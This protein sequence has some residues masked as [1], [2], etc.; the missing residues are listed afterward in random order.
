MKPVSILCLTSVCVIAF[1]QGCSSLG[2]DCANS[3]TC[4]AAGGASGQGGEAGNGG[5]GNGGQGGQGGGPP[6]ECIPSEAMGVVADSCGV[7]VSSSKGTAGAAGTK[8]E[9]VNTIAEAL[10]IA[11]GKPIY[12]CGEAFDEE[13]VMEA[14]TDVYGALDCENDWSYKPETKA[15]VN[16]PANAIAWKVSGSG[17][18][19]IADVAITAATATD[20][21]MSSI[22]MLVDESTVDL[23][24]CDI[25]AGDGADGAPGTSTGGTAQGGIMGNP[26]LMG[27][28]DGDTVNGGPGPTRTCA[29]GDT[30]TGGTGGLSMANQNGSTGN[31]GTSSPSVTTPLDNG[32][33]G[34]TGPAVGQECDNG[35]VGSV[36]DAGAQGAAAT[37]L[38]TLD[39]TGFVGTPGGNGGHGSPG[40]G[41]GGGGAAKGAV[42]CG[43]AALAAHSGGSGGAGGCGGEPGTGGGAGGSSIALMS[44]LATVTLADTTLT[45][46]DGGDAGGGGNAQGGGAGVNGGLA[47]GSGACNGGRGGDGGAGGAGGGGRGGH[48]L[49]IAFTGVEPSHDRASIVPGEAGDGGDGGLGN[50]P[51]GD[52]DPGVVAASHSFD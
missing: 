38:G 14:G 10:S 45:A 46:G 32:G 35:T 42:T 19:T 8:E 51:A 11:A 18:S 21:G 1:A 27:C 3:K 43:S 26:G 6:V 39:A 36:G 37:A 4:T 15:Q 20:P 9:P 31:G 30:S 41:G 34:E 7:F 23:V 49:G 52:G 40:Q 33:D 48:S 50:T 5:G 29:N 17:S 24:R 28:M 12:L 13:V 16:A 44:L 22:A 25:T 47:G 2:D